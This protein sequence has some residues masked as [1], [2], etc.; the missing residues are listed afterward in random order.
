MYQLCFPG[1]LTGET[2]VECP[3]C[4]TL[5]TVTVADSM[6]EELYECRDI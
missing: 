3:Y 1:A 6:G 4:Q 2:E 5:L